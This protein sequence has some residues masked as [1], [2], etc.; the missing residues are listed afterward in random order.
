M[1]RKIKRIQTQDPKVRE[2]LRQMRAVAGMERKK[3]FEDGGDVKQWRP[4]RSVTRN[5]KHH[6]NKNRC[7]KKVEV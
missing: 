6:E 5:R 7:R 4:I 1:P 2:A 3:F